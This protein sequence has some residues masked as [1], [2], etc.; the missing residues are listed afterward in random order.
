MAIGFDLDGV[1]VADY[2]EFTTGDGLGELSPKQIVQVTPIFKPTGNFY[3]ITGREAALKNVTLKWFN[4]HGI[5][6]KGLFHD[7]VGF[8]NGMQYKLKVLNENPHIT[9]YIESSERQV[10]FLQENL[11]TSCRVIH[12][13]KWIA[14]HLK[15]L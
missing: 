12:F 5:K 8:R 9:T 11:A 4:E 10:K 1:F 7:N 15:N 6:P 14:Q 2:T 3:V 13:A